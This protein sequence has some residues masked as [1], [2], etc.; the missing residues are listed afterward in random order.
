MRKALPIVLVVFLGGILGYFLVTGIA[1]LRHGQTPLDARLAR[2]AANINE[3]LPMMAD[4]DTRLDKVTAGPGAQLTYL[5]TLPNQE[6]SAIDP[7]AFE[8]ALRTNLINNYKTN[9]QME[10]MRA[11]KVSLKYQYKDKSGELF[12]QIVVTPKDF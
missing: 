5:F 3:K 11:A 10:E 12:S 2:V 7:T 8:N 6:K 1:E 9:S 4:A